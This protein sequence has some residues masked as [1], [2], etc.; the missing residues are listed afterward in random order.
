MRRRC[1]RAPASGIARAGC[2]KACSGESGVRHVIGT[3]FTQS[4]ML[5]QPFFSGA[6]CVLR[7]VAPAAGNTSLYP[8]QR[9]R[10]KRAAGAQPKGTYAADRMSG[11]IDH[12]IVA[13][14]TGFAPKVLLSS[15]IQ[16]ARLW[17]P[18]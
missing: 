13:Q 17:R 11:C 15:I 2:A 8:L 18:P 5:V 14:H 3:S 7:C 16:R 1:Y 4:P 10:N 12:F 6:R 9:C